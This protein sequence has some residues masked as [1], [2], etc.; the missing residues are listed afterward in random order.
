MVSFF[1]NNLSFFFEG[2]CISSYNYLYSD[3]EISVILSD[4]ES[5]ESDSNDFG[6][7]FEICFMPIV[8]IVI[9]IIFIFF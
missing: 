3:K 7:Y 4:K 9:R 1:E 6:F 8:F 5:Q 2:P